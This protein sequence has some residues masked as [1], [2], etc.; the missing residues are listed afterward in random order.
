MRVLLTLI[1]LC[2]GPPAYAAECSRQQSKSEQAEAAAKVHEK[3]LKSRESGDLA[4]AV[5]GFKQARELYHLADNRSAEIEMLRLLGQTTYLRGKEHKNEALAYLS[6]ALPLARGVGDPHVEGLLLYDI[7]LLHYKSGD[8]KN[9]LNALEQAITKL[10]LNRLGNREGEL[11]NTMA[12]CYVA[13]D[14]LLKAIGS[15]KLA[16]DFWRSRNPFLKAFLTEQLGVL[17]LMIG[18]YG[19][20]SQYLAQAKALWLE[21]QDEKAEARVVLSQALL[22]ARVGDYAA[23]VSQYER[24][25]STF[26]SLGLRTEEGRALSQLGNFYRSIGDWQRARR[27]YLGALEILTLTDS[28][29]ATARAHSEL[30]SVYRTTNDSSSERD[31]LLAAMVLYEGLKDHEGMAQTLFDLGIN[32]I[33]KGD[34]KKAL[35]LLNDSVTHSRTI[36]DIASESNT[37]GRIGRINA[38]LNNQEEAKKAIARQIVLGDL[39]SNASLKGHVLVDIGISYLTLKMNQDALKYFHFAFDSFRRVGSNRER[40][41]ALAGIALAHEGLGDLPAAL[42][43]YLESISILENMRTAG[44][45]EELQSPI[46]GLNADNYANAIHLSIKLDQPQQAFE[47]SERARAR[48]LLDQLGNVRIDPRRAADPKLVTE[49]RALRAQLTELENQHSL[50]RSGRTSDGSKQKSNAANVALEINALQEKYDALLIRLKA[51]NPEYVSMRTIDPLPLTEVQK[52]LDK[53][54]TL[55]SYFVTAPKAFAFVVTRSSFQ[56]VPLSVNETNLRAAVTQF[57]GFSQLNSNDTELQQL[58]LW[59]IK[60]LKPYLKT[61]VIGIVP[62]G[63][64]HYLPFAALTDGEKVFGEEHQLFYLPTASIVPLLQQKRK[65][66]PSTTLLSISQSRPLGLENLRNA[67]LTAT[68]IAK[69]YGTTA[70]VGPAASETTLRS[71]AANSGIIFIAAHGN[72][73]PVS[74]L[75]SRLVLAPDKENDG[76]LEVHEVYLMDLQKTDLVVLGSCQTQL[77]QQSRG[78]DIVSL[79]RA[80]IYAGTPTVIASLWRVEE[81]ATS[82]LMIALFK[83]LKKGMS[84]AAAL[85]AAQV[86]TRARYPSPYYWAGFVLVGDPE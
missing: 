64:L 20:A 25:R 34:Q 5:E 43:N 29:R 66:E 30:A 79:N 59:L 58:H 69:L 70:F 49:E 19:E 71:R 65:P 77:G 78:D 85:Q 26:Q 12:D 35:E 13:A 7:G 73:N 67:D 45:F 23:A 51:S 21:R 42:K 8:K 61:P 31:A 53:N 62:H 15:S 14:E 40:S 41:H 39:V 24:A 50:Q 47:L 83:N 3:A 48:N 9:A 76:M 86:Q 52:L 17:Y 27:S 32:Y 37:L 80:F 82:E 84:K 44:R 72:L 57:R 33:N 18:E 54:T 38:E 22:S 4:G 63:V 28:Y 56:A 10:T 16:L 1:L 75:F 6:E 36:N 55:V 74:P 11:H 81:R 46:A 60:P 68:E 2:F